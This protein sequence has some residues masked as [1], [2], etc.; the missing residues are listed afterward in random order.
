[1]FLFT[2]IHIMQPY[3]PDT[4]HEA[5]HSRESTSQEEN[6]HEFVPDDKETYQLRVT[7]V[8]DAFLMLTE[9]LQSCFKSFFQQSY[10]LPATPASQ[11]WR[12]AALLR[13]I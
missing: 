11:M 6:L 2:H 3:K 1:M 12:L 7:S 8:F 9:G 13:L 4:L 10:K 5:Q